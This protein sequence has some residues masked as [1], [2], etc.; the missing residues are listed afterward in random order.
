MHPCRS[1]SYV[2][3][4]DGRSA[5]LQAQASTVS[6]RVARAPR[7][8]PFPA[9]VSSYEEL[10]IDS[11]LLLHCNRSRCVMLDNASILVCEVGISTEAESTRAFITTHR[12]PSHWGKP[13]AYA[14]NVSIV[15]RKQQEPELTRDFLFWQAVHALSMSV[16]LDFASRGRSGSL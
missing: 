5:G 13:S 16:R 11:R 14:H 6:G 1:W 12:W 7:R 3:A 9:C 10:T 8:A 15:R 4:R 2:I